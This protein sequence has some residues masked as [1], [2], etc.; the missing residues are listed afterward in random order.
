[1][2]LVINLSHLFAHEYKKFLGDFKYSVH[3]SG[4]AKY[5]FTINW[6][7]FLLKFCVIPLKLYKQVFHQNYYMK[8]ERIYYTG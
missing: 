3:L 7:K 8:D 6:V 5:V 1:M 4:K 2:K